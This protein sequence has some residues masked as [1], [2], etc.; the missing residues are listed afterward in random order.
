MD[1]DKYMEM[2]QQQIID[3]NINEM[4]VKDLLSSDIDGEDQTQ[5]ETSFTQSEEKS[6]KFEFDQVSYF[7]PHN[8]S[9]FS[10]QKSHHDQESLDNLFPKQFDIAKPSNS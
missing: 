6:A 7:F 3:E 1:S 4:I 9:E 10:H 5:M 2:S 8:T